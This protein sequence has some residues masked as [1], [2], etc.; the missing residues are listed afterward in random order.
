M[1]PRDA[2]PVPLPK[3]EATQTAHGLRLVGTHVDAAAGMPENGFVVNHAIKV[4]V[5]DQVS[6]VRSRCWHVGHQMVCSH[7]CCERKSDL[8]MVGNIYAVSASWLSQLCSYV[9]ST[10]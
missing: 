2:E 6:A 3:K 4:Q 5:Q 8:F 9:G 7:D 10:H 1:L